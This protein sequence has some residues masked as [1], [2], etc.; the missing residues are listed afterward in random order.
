MGTKMTDIFV[1]AISQDAVAVVIYFTDANEYES[2]K[3]VIQDLKSRINKPVL[4]CLNKSLKVL[5]QEDLESF[6]LKRVPIN[7]NENGS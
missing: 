4:A 5:N 3:H 7:E 6:G 2:L 1:Q